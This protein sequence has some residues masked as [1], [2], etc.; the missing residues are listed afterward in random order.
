MANLKRQKNGR[1]AETY[2]YAVGSQGVT[3]P[4][5]TMKLAS[6]MALLE[7]GAIDIYDSIETGNGI[8]HFFDNAKP[9]TDAKPGGYGKLSVKNAFEKSSNIAI[10]RLIYDQFVKNPQRYVDY[11]H[12]FGLTKPLG[13]QMVGEGI[14]R[15]KGPDDPSW[16]GTS[17]PWMSIGYE[18]EMAPVHMLAF[19]NA[20]ANNGKLIQPIIVKQALRADRVI[21]NYQSK[22]LNK[23]ICSE[24]T[25]KKLHILLAGVVE[26]GTANNIKNANYSIA[27]KT[28][29]AQKLK[30]GKYT[31]QYYTSFAGYF[32]A[33]NPKYSCI[34]MIDNPKGYRQYATDVAAPVFKEIADKIYA[35]DIQMHEKMSE[36][37]N[38]QAGHFPLIQ[39][40]MREDLNQICNKMGV[41]NYGSDNQEWV[42]AKIV[43][44]SIKW[45]ERKVMTGLIPNVQ[46]MTL[47]DALYLLENS[48][49][50]VQFVGT[51]RVK[52]QSQQP[53]LRAI[54]GS[55]IELTLG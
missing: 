37:N 13:F 33:E 10:S 53:G 2:N 32:P 7:E 24:E 19:Y 11:L 54:Q 46:G 14:P 31:K 29:T 35:L 39:V 43:Q 55:K 22:T 38:Q 42:Q 20:V 17:L 36:E 34:V 1:Y 4:G 28:G 21:E 44:S 30:D 50:R 40:G 49:L 52:S 51:G 47:K 15:I 6:M 27:G 48:G 18:V 8:Y 9:M 25:L 16:S 12:Q 5:S 41:S 3:E 23:K 45:Q 26:N